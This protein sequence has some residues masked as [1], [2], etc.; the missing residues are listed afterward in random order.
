MT[1]LRICNH[2]NKCNYGKDNAGGSC[3]YAQPKSGEY[4]QPITG[5]CTTIDSFI[6]IVPFSAGEKSEDPNVSFR[7]SKIAT[8]LE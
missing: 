8:M 6:S 5:H 4:T 3:T 1:K 2:A 7:I